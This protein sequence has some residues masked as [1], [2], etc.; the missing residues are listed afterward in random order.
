MFHYSST[1]QHCKCS[2]KYVYLPVLN[3]HQSIFLAVIWWW[4]SCTIRLDRDD[5]SG[6]VM[7]NNRKSK[8]CEEITEN[9]IIPAILFPAKGY[10]AL[11]CIRYGREDKTLALHASYCMEWCVDAHVHEVQASFWDSYSGN[12]FDDWFHCAAN[13]YEILFQVQY[14]TLWYAQYRVWNPST[15]ML[16]TV[17]AAS[18]RDSMFDDFLWLKIQKKP[19]LC[20]NGWSTE[21]CKVI[22]RP[23]LYLTHSDGHAIGVNNESREKD[24]LS[25]PIQRIPPVENVTCWIK[26]SVGMPGRDTKF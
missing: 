4:R 5:Q 17:F 2:N 13:G 24:K 16:L 26:K 9:M 7:V 22:P 19:N 6:Q 18:F 21:E 1:K 10:G 8:K 3:N 11:D 23:T 15:V 14:R 20:E 12:R 25:V